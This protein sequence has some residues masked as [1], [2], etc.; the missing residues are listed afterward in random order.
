[1]VEAELNIPPPPSADWMD[2]GSRF[3]N[4]GF[5]I[6]ISQISQS[7]MFNV[8]CL[9]FITSFMKNILQFVL[10]LIFHRLCFCLKWSDRLC[11]VVE[12]SMQCC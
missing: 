9:I 5:R 6:S 7:L 2:K 11:K 3:T 1:M 4:S 10:T 12:L 8:K